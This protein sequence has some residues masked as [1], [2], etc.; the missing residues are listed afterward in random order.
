MF[1]PSGTIGGSARLRP[2]LGQMIVR[3]WGIGD[4]QNCS[5]RLNE[6]TYAPRHALPRPAHAVRIRNFA[7]RIS[8]QGEAET[9]V[10]DK[11]LMP[12]AL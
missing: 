3:L 1:C 9:V 4:V 7:V 5:I 12:H 11:L 8:Q 6:E 2:H 10:G